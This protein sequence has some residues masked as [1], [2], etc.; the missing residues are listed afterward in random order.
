[1]WQ[2]LDRTQRRQSAALLGLSVMY[3]CVL[4]SQFYVARLVNVLGGSA[5][6]A[7]LLTMISLLPILLLALAGKAVAQRWSPRLRLRAGLACSA[8]QLLLLAWAPKLDVLAPALL[9]SGFGYAL[10]FPVLMN[11]AADLVPK[12]YYTQAISYLTLAV[13]MGV[14][15]FSVMAAVVEPVAGTHS[16]FWIP[17]LL[18]LVAQ[19]M[20]GAVDNVVADQHA[21]PV[22]ARTSR[23]AHTSRALRPRLASGWEVVLLM[24]VLGLTFGLPLQF[25]PMWL[26]Q[27][28]TMHFSPAYFL[29]TSF[30]TIMATRLA[31]SHLLHGRREFRV[32]LV[33][34]ASVAFAV[35]ILGNAHTPWQFVVCALAYGG[36]Y[37]L[38]YPSCIAYLLQQ[39][40]PE[41]RGAWSN[42]VLLAY[43]AGSRCL[44]LLFGML[45]DHGGFPLSF[46]VLAVLIAIVGGWHLLKRMQHQ[47]ASSVVTAAQS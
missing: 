14:G 5:T 17:L 45:A 40:E 35:G 47:G 7:G 22:A 4:G 27:S 11:A 21:V 23:T 30:F 13:Q 1:M 41:Q 34:F 2:Q 36:T 16:V 9:L 38:L 25:V 15:L 29:T 19:S 37:S 18:A 39:V 8:L 46:R 28:P 6:T 31:F 3:G 33:C 44:P 10:C 42:W 32:L 24:G 12:A 43:E 20:V 26:A